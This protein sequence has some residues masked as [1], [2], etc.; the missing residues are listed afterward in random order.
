MDPRIRF[1]TKEESNHRREREFLAL[2]PAERVL[3]FLRSFNGREI[4]VEQTE[5]KSHNFIISRRIDAVR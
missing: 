4:V 2:A 1:E 5:D 3:W